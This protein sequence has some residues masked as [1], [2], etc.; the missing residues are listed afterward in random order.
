MLPACSSVADL[1]LRQQFF[2]PTSQIL[3]RLLPYFPFQQSFQNVGQLSLSNP[4]FNMV[5]AQ[6]KVSLGMTTGVTA[7]AGLGAL[8][9]LPAL[10]QIAG[11]SRTGT[12]QLACGLRYDKATRGIY[13][14]DPVLE[15]LEIENV[16]SALSN[17]FRQLVN[18][19]GPQLLNKYPIHTLD[20]SLASRLLTGMVVQENGIALQFGV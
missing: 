8:S 6:N 2:I 12:A 3:A 5:P 4:A 18:L 16:S 9:G 13:L 1:A 20:P 7:G 14:A 15:K 17:P 10:S 19:V 11:L